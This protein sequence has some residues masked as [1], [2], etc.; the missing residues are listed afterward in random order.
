MKVSKKMNLPMYKNPKLFE[1]DPEHKIVD[2]FVKHDPECPFPFHENDWWHQGFYL[3]EFI[4]YL[5]DFFERY[6]LSY[7]VKEME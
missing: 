1:Y 7:K 5:N 6:N 4:I 3:S 2:V